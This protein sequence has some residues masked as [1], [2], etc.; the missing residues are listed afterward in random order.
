MFAPQFL[1]D[2]INRAAKIA[3]VLAALV[4]GLQTARAEDI[5]TQDGRTYYRIRVLEVEP[6]RIRI[7]HSTGIT[8]VQYEQL[9]ARIRERFHMTEAAAQAA[10]A[11]RHEAEKNSATTASQPTGSPA[12]VTKPSEERSVSQGILTL[13]T[14]DIVEAARQ[15]QAAAAAAP[16]KTA[17][18]EIVGLLR[19][20]Q[21]RY[22]AIRHADQAQ[23]QA[24]AEI[25]RLKRN[26]GITSRPNVLD[27]NDRS[28]EQRGR[29]ML[30]QAQRLQ[31]DAEQT[32][33]SAKDQVGQT[34]AALET[35]AS[36]QAKSGAFSLALAIEDFVA[37][38]RQTAGIRSPSISGLVN[39]EHL[40]FQKRVAAAASH[41]QA[42]QAA[43]KQKKLI[44]AKRRVD[45]GLE[46]EPANLSLQRLAEELRTK[47]NSGAKLLSEATQLKANKQYE[48]AL[49]KVKAIEDECADDAAAAKLRDDLQSIVAEREQR[50]AQA[51]VVE[52]ASDY[53]SALTIYEIYDVRD[54]V[55]R[56]APLLAKAREKA[57]DFLAAYAL[58][59]RA[60]MTGEM[61]RV[62]A[63]KDNQSADYEQAKT[64]LAAGKFDEASAIFARYNDSVA[65]RD[66]LLRKA[67]QLESTDKYSEALDLYIQAK[68]A[69]EVA[70]VKTF[71]AEREQVL[72]DARDA[73]RAVNL[74]KALELFTRARAEV[75][76]RRIA[77]ALATAAEKRKDY[78][79]AAAYFETAGAFE[80]AARIR[81]SY[82]IETVVATRALR[83]E[84]VFKR[85]SPACV[86]VLGATDEGIA[87]G[88]GFFIR[89]GGYLLTN[90]HVVENAER[91]R[92]LLRGGKRVDAKVIKRSRTPDLALLRASIDD[93]PIL[94]LGDS[95]QVETGAHV[96]AIGS[97]NGYEQSFTAGNISAVDR[98]KQG[99]RCFQMSVLI[100]HGNSGGPL[101]N[102]FGQV[103]GIN[104][105]GEGTALISRDGIHI[106]S[107]IQGINFAIKIN[108]AKSLLSVIPAA[109]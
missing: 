89:K 87:L 79:S 55:Q 107:D 85:C 16:D 109:H 103:I 105:F 86:T 48:R 104:T 83:D 26:A 75:D 63:L 24:R 31:E 66:V 8:S 69:S 5:K 38:S 90:N 1:A 41:L 35:V 62:R 42:A 94:T 13:R 96:S 40:Q 7:V 56:V 71:I 49:E 20:L 27:P 45:E 76:I 106:G 65:Q 61:Q 36:R 60:G 44:E 10:R 12:E 15:F 102:E 54:S 100:N 93:H 84:E 3:A 95:D 108:E 34:L 37:A 51:R 99:N 88:S 72:R 11:K 47:L 46:Q 30:E 80:Q 33:R 52:Q 18:A 82:D 23:W 43:L 28:G 53:E 74:D 64:L 17:Y 4:A 29:E 39:A 50:L 6:D 68:A 92:V 67:A 25:D 101:L 22:A 81:K 2:K 78:A 58:Y 97:P 77:I 14:R 59:E 98:E 32:V 57:G 70:R 9:P 73:E 91:I 21:T 19:N